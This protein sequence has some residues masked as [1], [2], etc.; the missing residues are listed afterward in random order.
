MNYT[1]LPIFKAPE[2]RKANGFN[3]VEDFFTE[4]EMQGEGV[5]VPVD[6]LIANNRGVFQALCV[7]IDFGHLAEA[8]EFIKIN[9]TILKCT[10][11]VKEATV[12]DEGEKIIAE[13]YTDFSPILLLSP[14]LIRKES[15][16]NGAIQSI[17]PVM[18]NYASNEEVAN[19]YGRKELL[20]AIDLWLSLGL[21]PISHKE[22]GKVE[23]SIIDL[24]IDMEFGSAYL[25]KLFKLTFNSPMCTEYF[26]EEVAMKLYTSLASVLE[27]GRHGDKAQ[28]N[29]VSI[30]YAGITLNAFFKYSD[31][32]LF[33]KEKVK[34]GQFDEIYKGIYQFILREKFSDT[35][36]GSL[37]EIIYI[38]LRGLDVMTDPVVIHENEMRL[39]MEI[40]GLDP[41]EAL[42]M[43]KKDEQRDALLSIMQNG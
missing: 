39:L 6:E 26:G 23:Y 4:L 18:F 3:I 35:A 27:D 2:D 19:R 41:I 5:R 42:T 1:N 29:P 36:M 14:Y 15:L 37:A 43:V 34:A 9:P 28:V 7:L 21:S 20:E 16:L 31:Y 24:A 17:R 30:R 8:N 40:N 13:D 12:N 11:K 32:T 33:C 22:Q 25:D 38:L 10:F